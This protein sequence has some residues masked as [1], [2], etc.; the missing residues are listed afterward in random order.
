MQY[1]ILVISYVLTICLVLVPPEYW[2]TIMKVM[3][4]SEGKFIAKIKTNEM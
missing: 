4:G 1:L 3:A 2:E